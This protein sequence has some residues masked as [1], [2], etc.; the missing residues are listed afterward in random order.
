[1]KTSCA[2]QSPALAPDLYRR[3]ME[4][5]A[6]FEQST[7]EM[8]RFLAGLLS[9]RYGQFHANSPAL[10]APWSARNPQSINKAFNYL[11]QRPEAILHYVL[12]GMLNRQQLDNLWLWSNR[13]SSLTTQIWY[14]PEALLADE[15]QQRLKVS[16]NQEQAS[17]NSRFTDRKR[18]FNDPGQIWAELQDQASQWTFRAMAYGQS[19]DQAAIGF[20]TN[21]QLA[22]SEELEAIKQQRLSD[23]QFQYQRMQWSG[24]KVE[25]H[26]VQELWPEQ[27]D[28]Q[29]LYWQKLAQTGDIHLAQLVIRV[30]A[31]FSFGG[32][33]P[34]L[35]TLPELSLHFPRQPGLQL[36]MRVLTTRGE[37]LATDYW[38]NKTSTLEYGDHQGYQEALRAMALRGYSGV[39]KP[40]PLPRRTGTRS[41]DGYI[42]LFPDQF[43]YL[44]GSYLSKQGSLLTSEF[45]ASLPGDPLLASIRDTLIE[46]DRLLREQ[47]FVSAPSPEHLVRKALRYGSSHTGTLGAY[48]LQELD[49]L[50]GTGSRIYENKVL[51]RALDRL[52]TAHNITG[53]PDLYRQTSQFSGRSYHQAWPGYKGWPEANQWQFE[54][55]SPR[56]VPQSISATDASHWLIQLDQ[57]PLSAEVI[58]FLQSGW[59]VGHS[60]QLSAVDPDENGGP[61]LLPVSGSPP[62]LHLGQKNLLMLTGTASISSGGLQLSGLTA[63]ELAQ[64]LGQALKP[65]T[66]TYSP[67][68]SLDIQLFIHGHSADSLLETGQAAEFILLLRDRLADTQAGLRLQQIQMQSHLV[69]QDG[70]GRGWFCNLSGTALPLNWY[71]EVNPR[72]LA[73]VWSSDREPMAELRPEPLLPGLPEKDWRPL[74]ANSFLTAETYRGVLI[75]AGY[76]L[77]SR[78]YAHKVMTQ[79]RFT[80]ELVSTPLPVADMD[81]IGTMILTSLKT[82]KSYETRIGSPIEINPRIRVLIASDPRFKHNTFITD[83]DLVLAVNTSLLDPDVS[84]FSQPSVADQL[85]QVSSSQALID[86]GQAVFLHLLSLA[87]NERVHPHEYWTEITAQAEDERRIYD[88][89]QDDTCLNPDHRVQSGQYRGDSK[90]VS[91]PEA[92]SVL[93]TGSKTEFFAETLSAVILGLGIDNASREVLEEINSAQD[94]KGRKSLGQTPVPYPDLNLRRFHYRDLHHASQWLDF[95]QQYNVGHKNNQGSSYPR[96]FDYPDRMSIRP[97]GLSLPNYGV[98]YGVIGQQGTWLTLGIMGQGEYH[99]PL[100]RVTMTLDLAEAEALFQ[101]GTLSNKEV[102][103]ALYQTATLFKASEA[104]IRDRQE[105][106]SGSGYLYNSL[107]GFEQTADMVGFNFQIKL[108]FS[109]GLDN[110]HSRLILEPGGSPGLQVSLG[111]ADSARWFRDAARKQLR[112]LIG[113]GLLGYSKEPVVQ[114]AAAIHFLKV[115]PDIIASLGENFSVSLQELDRYTPEL[116]ADPLLAA[117]ASVFDFSNPILGGTRQDYLYILKRLS[118]GYLPYAEI[119]KLPE[120]EQTSDQALRR[121]RQQLMTEAMQ[122]LADQLRSDP[123]LSPELFLGV[124]LEVYETLESRSQRYRFRQALGYKN[125]SILLERTSDLGQSPQ[126]QDLRQQFI[127]DFRAID[128]DDGLAEVQFD[129]AGLPWWRLDPSEVDEVPGSANV[130]AIFRHS[131]GQPDI[132]RFSEYPAF[133]PSPFTLARIDNGSAWYLLL[134]N[135][136]TPAPWIIKQLGTGEYLP[137]LLERVT[138]PDFPKNDRQWQHYLGRNKALALRELSGINTEISIGIPAGTEGS[139]GLQEAALY[140]QFKRLMQD[141]AGYTTGNARWQRSL[142]ALNRL[143]TVAFRHTQLRLFYD[144]GTHQ[145]QDRQGRPFL[146]IPGG[147][148]NELL[149]TYY[150]RDP[151]I[152]MDGRQLAG[153]IRDFCAGGQ[154]Q[155]LLLLK[156]SDNTADAELFREARNGTLADPVDLMVITSEDIQNNRYRFGQQVYRAGYLSPKI[157]SLKQWLLWLKPNPQKLPD[158]ND[159]K[160]FGIDPLLIADWQAEFEQQKARVRDASPGRIAGNTWF[161]GHAHEYT[162]FLQEDGLLL[163]HQDGGFYLAEEFINS[164]PTLTF[165]HNNRYPLSELAQLALTYS[166]PAGLPRFNLPVNL[167]NL[168]ANNL[169]HRLNLQDSHPFYLDG[170]GLEAPEIS[171]RAE[172][173]PQLHFSGPGNTNL[174]LVLE[175]YYGHGYAAGQPWFR[176]RQGG[177]YQPLQFAPDSEASADRFAVSERTPWADSAYPGRNC[178][179]DKAIQLYQ[180]EPDHVT[181][182]E[183]ED[184]WQVSWNGWYQRSQES[185]GFLELLFNNGD[186]LLQQSRYLAVPFEF[187]YSRLQVTADGYVWQLGTG[188]Q[189]MACASIRLPVPDLVQQ[190]ILSPWLAATELYLHS[191]GAFAGIYFRDKRLDQNAV[192]QWLQDNTRVWSAAVST[193]EGFRVTGNAMANFIPVNTE[194]IGSYQIDSGAGNNLVILNGGYFSAHFG[195]QTEATGA[196]DYVEQPVTWPGQN[197]EGKQEV[198]RS[199]RV[200]PGQEY[201][202]Q[203]HTGTGQNILDLTRAPSV[204]L[205]SNPGSRNLIFLSEYSRADLT[206]QYNATFFLSGVNITG[207]QFGL[208]STASG[209]FVDDYSNATAAYIYQEGGTGYIASLPVDSESRLYSSDTVIDNLAQWLSGNNQPQ[210]IDRTN[211]T[212]L[213]EQG[214]L[215]RNQI[216]GVYDLLTDNSTRYDQEPEDLLS[217]YRLAGALQRLVEDMGVYAFGGT[218]AVSPEPTASYSSSS[219]VATLSGSSVRP[220]PSVSPY[221]NSTF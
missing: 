97:S 128:G 215:L 99:L 220:L 176:G 183:M 42:L 16:I 134:N 159:G 218:G 27:P 150:P 198:R 58:D 157:T 11:Q 126:W 46:N 4:A 73:L 186:L 130:S 88:C 78:G 184:H 91:L 71:R 61:S 187:R 8:K 141:S 35:G 5:L 161:S 116:K 79:D 104:L 94:K 172:T 80:V 14:D 92:I 9:L 101:A 208:W 109:T 162:G 85:Y 147:Y 140:Q 3:L 185:G 149:V 100:K 66:M 182:T 60:Y 154:V 22:T 83:T 148:S 48:R 10:G 196:P 118:H 45:M 49:L 52:G 143:N 192:V 167:G 216:N 43:I 178:F 7:P 34:D 36:A 206:S 123:G 139:E 69:T 145:L 212:E 76:R 127:K 205:T 29:R 93:A 38:L 200:R 30:Q 41:G 51:D 171:D 188:N 6:S 132:Y 209:Q 169:V 65:A 28:I 119:Q 112:Y 95:L 13:H 199:F 84:P 180:L 155:Q 214:R 87:I 90:L 98:D 108:D 203:I 2:S 219:T 193:S 32:Y 191:L 190:Q 197:L 152:R 50:A 19:F 129:R 110:S 121:L 20:L 103:D 96:R 89:S 144:Q 202:I 174:T 181:V 70:M 165:K 135:T 67:A 153:F 75:P 204:T 113:K 124:W 168:A 173:G 33:S 47:Q 114:R 221:T 37:M 194:T 105:L 111:V 12:A 25:L 142:V 102:D 158:L 213:A 86:R 210:A 1:M 189:E 77:D 164:D 68:A 170:T 53:L 59:A 156:P 57:E 117:L 17:G 151:Q 55:T 125:L 133:E 175:G 163:E 24:L 63:E 15:L 40:L 120:A 18:F 131:S 195:W 146:K 177:Y 115:E 54:D 44:P 122:Q 201:D 166:S 137:S 39:F 207:L 64:R 211:N 107:M 23:L 217:G 160:D 31:L 74:S 179:P 21:R 136:E 62:E 26:A 72:A 106:P 82:L 81:T 56:Y 138:A